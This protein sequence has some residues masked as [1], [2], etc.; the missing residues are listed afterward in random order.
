MT[1]Y[2]ENVYKQ[3]QKKY[4]LI[5]MIS[6]LLLG[7][8]ALFLKNPL[9]FSEPEPTGIKTTYLVN[10]EITSYRKEFVG[11]TTY[12]I[13]TAHYSGYANGYGPVISVVVCNNDGVTTYD[14]HVGAG[15]II[16]L[17]ERVFKVINYNHNNIE[18]MDISA[19]ALLKNTPVLKS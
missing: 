10:E 2:N 18:L 3:K 17:G 14:L 12:T 9:P 4:V 11:E 8:V 15:T 16:Q 1:E 19:D 6:F 7:C 5:A 13:N